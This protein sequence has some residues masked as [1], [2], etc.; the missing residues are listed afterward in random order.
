MSIPRG[1]G[2][3][4]TPIQ[5]D[6]SAMLDVAGQFNHSASLLTDIASAPHAYLT[7]T[8]EVARNI[9]HADNFSHTLDTFQTTFN[10][11]LTRIAAW[12]RVIS[13]AQGSIALRHA[14]IEAH[15]SSALDDGAD[16]SHHRTI[17]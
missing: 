5:L 15:A 12:M 7:H 13:H 3:D 1:E 2:N 11:S 9:S 4:P 10:Q 6:T 8:T 17:S 16:R 14:S